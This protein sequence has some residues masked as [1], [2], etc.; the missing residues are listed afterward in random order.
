MPVVVAD[1][2]PDKNKSWILYLL[3]CNDG[4]FY[5]GITNDLARRLNQHQ[6][7]RASRYT[8]SRRPVKI[9]YSKL[10][11]SRSHALKRERAVKAL[12]RKEKAKLIKEQKTPKVIS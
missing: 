8:R 3:R 5:A 10:C 11:V 1:E 12:T 4:S 9:V 2:V 6:D 7:G